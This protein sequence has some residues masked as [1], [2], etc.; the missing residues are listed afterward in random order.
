MVGVVVEIVV[1]VFIVQHKCFNTN[2]ICL[3][4]C[5][6]QKSHDYIVNCTFIT[7]LKI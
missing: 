1:S 7:C 3:I 2:E 6:C 5:F 4:L